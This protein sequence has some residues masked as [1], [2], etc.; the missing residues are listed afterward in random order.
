MTSAIPT[1]AGEAIGEIDRTP[2][3]PTEMKS[4]VTC[5]SDDEVIV[6]I[7]AGVSAAAQ[8]RRYMKCISISMPRW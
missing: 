2:S 5:V 4:A 1:A 6:G 3:W 8:A 7:T